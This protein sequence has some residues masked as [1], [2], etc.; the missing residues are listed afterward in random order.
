MKQDDVDV[1]MD[2]INKRCRFPKH[3]NEFIEKETEKYNYIIKDTKNKN[4]YCTKCHHNFYNTKYKINNFE[5]CPSC[6]NS[7]RIVSINRYFQSFCKSVLL[8]QKINKEIVI[9]VFEI[10]TFYNNKT[11]DMENNIV[12]YC[13]IIPGKGKFISSNVEFHLGYMRIYHYNRYYY[14][15]W[16]EYTGERFFSHFT[17][18]PFNKKRLL[19]GTNL[20]Y[21]PIE[22]FTSKNWSY[23]YIDGL[24]LAGYPSFEILWNMKLYK[25]SLSAK[26]LNKNG[27]FYKRFKLSK[28]YLKFMQENDIDYIELR[29][30]QLVKTKDYSFIK[31]LSLCNYTDIKFLQNEGILEEIFKY[32]NR[33]HTLNIQNLKIVQKFI[34]LRKLKQYPKGLIHLDI[35][36]DYLLMSKKLA[37]NYKSKKDLFPRNLMSRHDKMQNKIKINEDIKTQYGVYLRYLEL[38]KY[39]YTDDKYI[40]FPAPSADDL[41]D[42]GLQQKNCVYNM[43]LQPYINKRTEIFFIREFKDITKSF[44]T[45]EYKDNSVV[46]KE[47]PNHSRE[48]TKEQLNFID[49]WCQYRDFVDKRE[50]YYSKLND[51]HTINYDL[52]KFAA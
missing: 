49:K 37:L 5:E 33:I 34:P 52:K 9:R 48:F 3:W 2:K 32:Q 19:K 14:Q 7:F 44:I 15:Y 47:L 4:L 1:M 30:L 22:E 20:E 17:T 13:R 27:S 38:S 46:Q 45:L 40:I 26:K 35:Y 8:I 39:C 11:K 36:K 25:L 23:N 18:Y 6:N 16:R 29:R 24:E 43:Y 51:E 42:E 50:K 12:E 10:E 31:K 21:A 41:K 28:D